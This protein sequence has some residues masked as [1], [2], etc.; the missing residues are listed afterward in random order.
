MCPTKTSIKVDE[1][2]GNFPGGPVKTP[3]SQC[4]GYRFEP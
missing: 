3:H 1:G 4:R 2:G